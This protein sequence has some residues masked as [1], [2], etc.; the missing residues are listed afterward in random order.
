M[1]T[2]LKEVITDY[3]IN[4]GEPSWHLYAECLNYAI[5]GYRE[6]RTDV[7]AHVVEEELTPDARKQ[8]LLPA[9]CVSVVAVG[10][11]HG[12]RIEYMVEDRNIALQLKDTDDDGTVDPNK[13]FFTTVAGTERYHKVWG[14]NHAGVDSN[15]ENH[16]R[17][18]YDNLR[19]Q[20]GSELPEGQKIY[21]IYKTS[22]LSVTDNSTIDYTARQAMMGYIHWKRCMYDIRMGSSHPETRQREFD[23]LEARRQ[24]LMTQKGLTLK[25][26]SE[27]SN[28][29]HRPTNITKSYYQ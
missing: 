9:T 17:I 11:K 1:R 22:G 5:H 13:S 21:L 16:Y 4:I 27:A 7:D 28:R 19:I 23:Y 8:L 29:R 24:W 6:L 14:F 12:D 2:T 25:E 10:I 18:D 3:L 15:F 26:I 20:F